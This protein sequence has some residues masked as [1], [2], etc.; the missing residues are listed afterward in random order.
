MYN[1][2][3]K[4][5]IMKKFLAF[6]LALSVLAG[7]FSVSAFAAEESESASLCNTNTGDPSGDGNINLLDVSL[8]LKH[9]AKWQGLKINTEQADTV[10]DG[11]INLADVSMLLRYIAKWTTVRLGHNDTME[12]IEN[13][14][15]Q[16]E[17]KYTLTCKACGSVKTV[18]TPK[19]SC[20]YQRT[21]FKEATC[22]ETGLDKYTCTM[23][24]DSYDTVIPATGKHVYSG[25]VCSICGD[26]DP[27]SVTVSEAQ[28]EVL[29]LVNIERE[30]VGIAPLSYY[31]A[32]Q[33]AGDIRAEE[34]KTSFG[35]TRPNG[36]SCFTVL[37]ESGVNYST[38]GENIAMGHS[39]PAEVVEAWM[40]SE[41]H[42]A[43][44]LNAD[45]THLIVG[46]NGLAW[47]QLFIG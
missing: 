8:I 44:I 30:K 13:A 28:L 29:R 26:P 40:N 20:D 17:G 31:P 41:G 27:D 18:T 1:R 4:E 3:D 45:F 16:T 23:C 24:G 42:R 11:N 47:V 9:I 43:N 35:H 2:A 46:I 22:S 12:V 32:G 19:L 21:S 10:N 5:K 36:T 6:C 37:Q 14:T 39:T 7:A 34:I 15:C 25:G 38:A 33:A